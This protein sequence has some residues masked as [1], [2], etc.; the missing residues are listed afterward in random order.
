[1]TILSIA[2]FTAI[3]YI[4]NPL[5]LLAF[6]AAPIVII[7]VLTGSTEFGVLDLSQDN[8]SLAQAQNE[9]NL[10]VTIIEANGALRVKDKVSMASMFI[11]LFYGSLLTSYSIISDLK[12]NTHLRFKASPIRFIE[13]FIGKSLGHIL[14]MA[15]STLVIFI[16]TKFVLEVN[17]NGNIFII[18]LTFLLFLTIVN[19]FGI[20]ITGFT[21]NIYISALATFAV[22]FTMIFGSM[23]EAF[24]PIDKSS[25]IHYFMKFSI[26]NYALKTLYG[27]IMKDTVLM[28]NSLLVLALI[29]VGM[30]ILSYAIGRRVLK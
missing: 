29:A 26:Q 23:S 6:I 5:A 3:K 18:L 27:S 10:K 11:F 15:I 9:S 1:M 4:R 20:I 25:V 28:Q 12:K 8:M 21:R 14:I 30:I 7:F 17:W 24:T 2:Y 19:S 16:I 22:N 13:N